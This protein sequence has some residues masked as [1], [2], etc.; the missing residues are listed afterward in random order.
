MPAD[1]TLTLHVARSI[2]QGRIR[3]QPGKFSIA[4]RA[5]HRQGPG[6]P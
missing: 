6:E 4:G 5:R 2:G 1:G 3:T